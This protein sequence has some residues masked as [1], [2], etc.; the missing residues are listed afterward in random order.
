MASLSVILLYSKLIKLKLEIH[1]SD[2][3]AKTNDIDTDKLLIN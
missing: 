2:L 3:S 1:K